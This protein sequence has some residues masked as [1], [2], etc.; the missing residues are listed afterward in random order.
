MLNRTPEQAPEQDDV[1]REEPLG[2]AADTEKEAREAQE[3][4]EKDV[5]DAEN[6][7]MAAILSK[8][9]GTKLSWASDNT[10]ETDQE[11]IAMYEKISTMSQVAFNSTKKGDYNLTLSGETHNMDVQALRKDK[12]GVDQG[13][14][15]SIYRSTQGQSN[16]NLPHVFVYFNADGTPK[17]VE[18]S[19]YP[20]D[21]KTDE[22]SHKFNPEKADSPAGIMAGLLTKLASPDTELDTSE[23]AKIYQKASAI[24]K[25]ETGETQKWDFSENT[26]D[27]RAI[28]FGTYSNGEG[29]GY[30]LMVDCKDSTREVGNELA[31][32]Y[33]DADGAFRSLQSFTIKKKGM[34]LV[35]WPGERETERKNGNWYIN[36]E[37]NESR[38]GNALMFGGD[39]NNKEWRLQEW[40]KSASETDI[41]LI[42]ASARLVEVQRMIQELSHE[43]EEQNTEGALFIGTKRPAEFLRRAKVLENAFNGVIKSKIKNVEKAADEKKET[44]MFGNQT[45]AVS[46]KL[47]QLLETA[48]SLGVGIVPGKTLSTEIDVW[49]EVNYV[50]RNESDKT[51]EWENG[52]K[53][54]I[55]YSY[56]YSHPFSGPRFETEYLGSIDGKSVDTDVLELY[57]Q[58]A[59]EK[60][61]KLQKENPY[62]Y[63]RVPYMTM[64]EENVLSE[65]M[66]EEWEVAEEKIQEEVRERR[67][68]LKESD[69][70]IDTGVQSKDA[71]PALKVPQTIPIPE[72]LTAEAQKE[73]N[74]IKSKM[75]EKPETLMQ[76]I[77]RFFEKLFG[78]AEVSTEE[79]QK[80]NK[81]LP[82]GA[83]E[84]ISKI[85]SDWGLSNDRNGQG[86]RYM[87]KKTITRSKGIRHAYVCR[88]APGSGPENLEPDGQWKQIIGSRLYQ[89]K[90]RI[91]YETQLKEEYESKNRESGYDGYPDLSRDPNYHDR[92]GKDA[93][94][95][96]Q[97]AEEK[98]L[99]KLMPSSIYS[100]S[101]VQHVREQGG[102]EYFEKQE[103]L[104]ND[105]FESQHGAVFRGLEEAAIS[106]PRAAKLWD[107]A[108][109]NISRNPKDA[110]HTMAYVRSQMAALR[111]N[112][113]TQGLVPVVTRDGSK[114]LVD[115]VPAIGQVEHTVPPS[116]GLSTSQVIRI[117]K[118]G[119]NGFACTVNDPNKT[120]EYPEDAKRMAE[121]GIGVEYH[122]IRGS[123]TT[124]SMTVYFTQPGTYSVGGKEVI[125]P[126]NAAPSA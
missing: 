44:I 100:E 12:N 51:K 35:E 30:A 80:I 101:T 98:N 47:K 76:K 70:P 25:E 34:L 109:R 96:T 16:D 52:E 20:A 4:A 73:F 119:S 116:G 45:I 84:L 58:S 71:P 114:T 55:I 108:Q 28:N 117:S 60:V 17:K 77:A 7:K 48:K 57:V 26:H 104:K 72:N 63:S 113:E 38:N 68:M 59:I 88:Y 115:G 56:H 5:Q 62:Q 111:S 37:T 31:M 82:P 42:E 102:S 89:N 11:H 110:Y 106:D 107:A 79:N 95:A 27:I 61:Q 75:D 19:F 87:Y 53:L 43:T 92:T 126:G 49:K 36:K 13:Y 118:E 6:E 46:T 85:G 1:D 14:K 105:Y 50:R 83:A 22:Y 23:R 78:I 69:K 124:E 90:L 8:L 29:Q 86:E 18:C 9:S 32:L 99:R 33:F 120:V 24:L 39:Q 94:Y 41:P 66:M 121:A 91:I 97:R 40:E 10:V 2:D 81:E 21:G 93:A 15:V 54:H 123:T 74:A 112:K 64:S 122:K 3:Q 125:V 65:K 103:N 67:D